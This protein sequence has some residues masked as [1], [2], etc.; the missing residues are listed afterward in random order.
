[1][2]TRREPMKN[3]DKESRINELCGTPRLRWPALRLA[4]SAAAAMPALATAQPAEPAPAAKTDG[5]TDGPTRGGG[6]ETI[7]VTGLRGEQPSSTKLPLSVRETPQ[8][9][10][11]ITRDSL[12]RRQVVTLGQALELSAGVTQFS[13][14]GPF[15]G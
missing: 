2:A 3:P 9:I 7:T 8:S 1:M 14:N 6:V 5:A 15:A 11:I 4:L 10:S 13:G 12:D